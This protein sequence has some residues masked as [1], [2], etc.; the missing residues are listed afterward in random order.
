MP[1]DDLILNVRQIGQYPPL[2]SVP[3][4]FSLVL[5]NGLGGPYYSATAAA[6][7]GTALAEAG[8][9]MVGTGPAPTDA[10]GGQIFTD[11]LVV[12][13]GA[14]HNWNCYFSI[15]TDDF[16][17]LNA[18]PSA[19][20]G[21][22]A[23][24]EFVWN[25]GAAQAAG[26]EAG[27]AA[28]MALS[29]DGLSVYGGLNATAASFPSA[30]LGT[31]SVA[32][33]MQVG[34]TANMA[35]AVVQTN[36]S[37]GALCAL[38]YLSVAQTLDAA[39]LN[40]CNLATVGNLIVNGNVAVPNGAITIG[41]YTVLTT[42]NAAPFGFAPL[43]SPAFTGTP[44]APTPTIAPADNSNAIA[45]TAFVVGVLNQALSSLA[46]TFAPINNPIF[47]GL[48][49]APTAQPGNATGQ[50]ATTAFVMNAVAAATAG[51]AS[52]NTRTGA[53]VLNTTD[54]IDAGGA[55]INSPAFLGSPVA[56]TAAPGT[57]TTQLATT[58]FVAAAIASLSGYAPLN[59]PAFI[60]TPTAPTPVTGNNSTLIATTAFVQNTL[61]AIDAG[62]IS[63]NGRS[64]AVSLTAND[65]SAA[66]GAPLG[67]PA[68]YGVPTA[69]TPPPGT[70]TTQL[71]TAAFV[72]AAIAAISGVGSFNGRSGAV[73]LNSTDITGAGGVLGGPY[74]PMTGGTL[75]GGL[76]VSGANLYVTNA[77]NPQTLYTVPGVRAWWVGTATAGQFTIFDQS[78]G[79]IR[80]QWDING[81]LAMSGA[82]SCGG[83][84]AAA[85]GTFNSSL[86][87][88][89][90]VLSNSSGYLYSS[91]GFMA[92]LLRFSGAAGLYNNG[93]IPVVGD[94]ANMAIVS[95]AASPSGLA[96]QST[97]AANT[98]AYFLWVDA[99]S[100]IRIKE[101]IVD[102]SV[103]ALAV[104]M[105][106][107]IRAFDFN[108]A[109]LDA[110]R[111]KGGERSRSYHVPI[112]LVAQEAEAV[113]PE[114]VFTTQQP[115]G[116]AS[117]IPDDMHGIHL[118]NA[119]PYLIRAVQQL[120]VRVRQLES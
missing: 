64:G 47:T 24:G 44:T 99:G 75:T 48:P 86:N 70:N 108:K 116:H 25:A 84:F 43:A 22:A 31:L 57:A 34:G 67:S 77:A 38:G 59:S 29:A 119:I 97:D 120:E 56:P 89:G 117:N 10:F 62:V 88:N 92:P 96:F 2:G 107:P 54:I 4:G 83:P 80:A 109:A 18:G 15:S 61:T 45:T 8:P 32:G 50:L 53:V 1:A 36:L 19:S 101:N 26:A 78:A 102:T 73:V 69:P 113:I 33:D 110:I 13:L 23:S 118:P 95:S 115:E 12:N 40:V 11:N 37:V 100:D 28:L 3:P 42:G 63:F 74:L 87:I 60:G 94:I 6:L 21:F 16:V 68:L 112:G 93:N 90:M 76:T 30:Q 14:T 51:V 66:G 7:V 55:P 27:Q 79:V 103:D 41:G 39:N 17:V 65:I 85:A 35:A 81:N 71:A 104:L 105:G 5:Q 82:I 9:L 106:M 72:Q 49:T 114:M 46:T 20:F 98:V 91:S 52:F 58:A 111:P